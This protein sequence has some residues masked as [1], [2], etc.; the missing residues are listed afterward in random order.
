MTNIYVSQVVVT[1]ACGH[2]VI[3]ILVA[4]TGRCQFNFVW[5][6]GCQ[7]KLVR[8]GCH[9]LNLVRADRRLLNLVRDGYRLLT[10]AGRYLHIL[11]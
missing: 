11:R 2:R 9:L 3:T 10:R 8:T 5:T 4:V 1:R 7:L 6:G